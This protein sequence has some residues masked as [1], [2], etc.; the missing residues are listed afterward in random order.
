MLM[1]EEETESHLQVR[2]QWKTFDNYFGAV[3]I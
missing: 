2:E 3:L 1:I